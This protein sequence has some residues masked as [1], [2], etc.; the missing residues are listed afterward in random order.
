M[1]GQKGFRIEFSIKGDV[2]SEK[3]GLT[4]SSPPRSMKW[5]WASEP[6]NTT[7]DKGHWVEML[8]YPHMPTRRS[9]HKKIT[10][11]FWE[12]FDEA[13]FSCGL[14]SRLT[15]SRL[16]IGGSTVLPTVESRSWLLGLFTSQIMDKYSFS[17]RGCL[18]DVKQGSYYSF[19]WEDVKDL[20]VECT[21]IEVCLEFNLW[22]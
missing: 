22:S 8:H 4:L 11:T 20:F 17:C 15:L 16:S 2:N 12:I 6:R 21:S 3:R 13:N 7:P 9:P 14:T 10:I 18:K 1:Q 5:L 19:I